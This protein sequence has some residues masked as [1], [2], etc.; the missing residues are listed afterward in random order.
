MALTTGIQRRDARHLQPSAAFFQRRAQARIDDG[1]HHHARRAG[2]LLQRP[3]Q[4]P[5]GTNQ[6]V[7]VFDRQDVG[8]P[9][10]DGAA[11]AFSVSPVESDTRWIWK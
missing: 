7:D 1:V 10:A 11:I 5:R 9:G 3:I 2:D 6:G 8:E 4:L